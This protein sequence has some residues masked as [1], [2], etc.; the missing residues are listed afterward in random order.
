MINVDNYF[1]QCSVGIVILITIEL[2]LVELKRRTAQ[3]FRP[4]WAWCLAFL[5]WP[6]V[7]YLLVL[8][9]FALSIPYGYVVVLIMTV[10]VIQAYRMRQAEDRQ[11]LQWF[12]S[13]VISTG[14]SAPEAFETF[15]GNR[16]TMLSQRCRAF[17][18]QLRQGATPTVAAKASRLPLSVGSLLLLED[19]P[20]GL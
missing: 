8:T 1:L 11:L 3:T 4:I 2:F 13:A 14:E 6:V 16:P 7:I 20:A 9:S 12:T 18:Y 19:G 17:A 15:A 5:R 10:M